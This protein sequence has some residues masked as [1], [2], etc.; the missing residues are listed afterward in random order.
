MVSTHR[1]RALI[2]HIMDGELYIDAVILEMTDYDLIIGMDFLSKYNASI[3]C[4]RRQVIFNQND[5][6][7]FVFIGEMRKKNKMFLSAL[8]AKR[9]MN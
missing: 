8:D 6:K 9:L 1:C 2:V 3:E 7:H 4:R 5:D